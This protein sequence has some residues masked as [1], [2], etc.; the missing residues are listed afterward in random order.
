MYP[1]EAMSVFPPFTTLSRFSEPD[2]NLAAYNYRATVCP[3]ILPWHTQM[4]LREYAHVHLYSHACT[5]STCTMSTCTMSTCAQVII[6][7]RASVRRAPLPPPPRPPVDTFIAEPLPSA[8]R[9][10]APLGPEGVP[11]RANALGLSLERS[12]HVLDFAVR[13]V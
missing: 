13:S 2:E 7:L 4:H 9:M 1:H 12:I 8:L 5:M 6:P 10:D 3:C 11:L